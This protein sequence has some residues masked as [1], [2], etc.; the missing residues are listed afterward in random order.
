VGFVRS[1]PRFVVVSRAFVV[2]G[3]AFLHV[4]LGFVF[5]Q[6]QLL[7]DGARNRCLLFHAEPALVVFA[8]KLQRAG[9][10]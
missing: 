4:R 3:A 5:S 2:F 10:A 7:H 6:T 8:G 9:A 1:R